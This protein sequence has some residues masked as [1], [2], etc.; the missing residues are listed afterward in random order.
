M[1][2]LAK[3]EEKSHKF[4]EDINIKEIQEEKR[5]HTFRQ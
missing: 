3:G 2:T 5:S 4:K 1:I